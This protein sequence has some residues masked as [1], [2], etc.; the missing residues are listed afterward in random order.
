MRVCLTYS[1]DKYYIEVMTSYFLVLLEKHVVTLEE[2]SI[3][4]RLCNAG[5]RVVSLSVCLIRGTFRDW[6]GKIGL[7]I[8]NSVK[9]K[10]VGFTYLQNKRWSSTV[11]VGF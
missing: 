4:L 1:Y 11:T 8:E 9:A 2:Q 7:E 3:I 6:R 10:S 5:R